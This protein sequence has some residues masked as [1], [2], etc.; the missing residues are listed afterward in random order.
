MHVEGMKSMG[1]TIMLV[2]VL[3]LALY[4]CL[5][6]I[7]W[8]TLRVMKP[9]VKYPGILIFSLSGHCADVEMLIRSVTVQS[10]WA[11]EMTDS[12]L[13]LDAGM[14][15]ETR[16]LAQEICSQYNNVDIRSPEELEKLFPS[17]LH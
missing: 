9:T 12:I 11:A 5:E 8:I 2:I 3:L 13:L 10:R 14:D 4:G 7:R 1:D 6:L 17:G 16:N 15:E